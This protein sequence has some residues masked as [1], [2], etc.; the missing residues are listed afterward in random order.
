MRTLPIIICAVTLPS[1][2]AGCAPGD[3]EVD[4]DIDSKVSTRVVVTWTTDEP[5]SS[6]VEYGGPDL[7]TTTT[8]VSDQQSDD[9][10][11]YLLGLPAYQDVWY[12]AVTV[13]GGRELAVEGEL[14]TGGIP[15][16]I[17]DLTVTV[18]Q[19][20][21][22][23]QE[24]YLVGT[25]FGL[26]SCLFAIDRQ[27]RVLWYH[28]VDSGNM[29]VELELENNGP[30]FYYNTFA[31]DYTEDNGRIQRLSFTGAGKN[32]LRTE[33]AHHAFTQLPDGGLAW[34]TLDVRDWT[35]PDDGTTYTVVGD[36][37][38]AQTAAGEQYTAFSIWDWLEPVITEEWDD[39]FYGLGKDWSHANALRYEEETGT[40]L[41]SLRNLDTVVELAL[42][43]DDGLLTPVR[44]LEGM[45][46]SAMVPQ[47]EV[48][49]TTPSSPHFD[50]L[51]DP[52]I[53]ADGTF[54]A[55]LHL[56]GETQIVEYDIIDSTHKLDQVWSY[57][58]GEGLLT[59]FLGMA[60]DLD[61]GNRLVSFASEGIVREVTP[62]GEVAWE[63]QG[64]AGALF[65]NILPF[66]D[67][68]AP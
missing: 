3:F 48:Y 60:R 24:P 10:K 56:A 29:P 49:R 41:L 1:A 14:T 55:Q 40:L 7:E 8:P 22:Q 39:D 43:E 35:D 2:L 11:H 17:P 19:R 54:M 12:R 20:G 5:G 18:D 33:L 28:L 62:E 6:W 45:N 66:E 32:K 50:Y 9:H 31:S 4:A 21:L 37:I 53:T 23:S 51:H 47:A 27:G 16:E 67:F 68:Y 13:V 59:Y 36:A 57:G 63:L 58:E 46:G 61:N 26:V 38:E 34:L 30:G 64:A 15:P 25:A 52:T 42:D 65:G 44:Q